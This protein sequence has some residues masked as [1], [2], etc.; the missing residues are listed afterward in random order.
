MNGAA[1]PGSLPEGAGSP[2]GLTEGVSSDGCFVPMVIRKPSW[3]LKFLSF[4]VHRSTLPQLRCA[5]Q[6]PQRGSRETF[7]F[8][9]VLAKIR[10]WRAIFIAPTERTILRVARK[11][12]KVQPPSPGVGRGVGV[13]GCRRRC[14]RL[15]G[16]GCHGGFLSGGFRRPCRSSCPPAVRRHRPGALRSGRRPGR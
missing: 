1:N 11:K 2:Q 7:P 5:Q 4:Y 13:I 3:A 10:G 16:W 8:N 9:R 12:P 6:L 14:G 15:F